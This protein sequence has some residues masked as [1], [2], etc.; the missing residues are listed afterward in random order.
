MKVTATDGTVLLDTDFSA[1]NPF[2]G[3]TLTAQGLRVDQRR[4]VL[5]RSPDGNMPLLRTDFATASGK[6]VESARVYATARG[7]YEL[8]PQRRE[9]R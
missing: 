2:D 6:T 7:I 8:T 1:G 3:G 4:D 5:W 9:G